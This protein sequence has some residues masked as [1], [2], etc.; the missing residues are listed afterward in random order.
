MNLI[1]IVKYQKALFDEKEF[2][3]ETTST[4][5]CGGS[6]DEEEISPRKSSLTPSTNDNHNNVIEFKELAEIYQLHFLMDDNNFLDNCLLLIYRKY[7]LRKIED[8]DVILSKM[9]A[10]LQNFLIEYRTT[11]GK[12]INSTYI[13]RMYKKYF[14]Y[15]FLN[16]LKGRNITSREC[17]KG[18]LMALVFREYLLDFCREYSQADERMNYQESNY[19]IFDPTRIKTELQRLLDLTS[20]SK[21]ELSQEENVRLLRTVLV[22]Q[23][24]RGYVKG[25]NNKELFIFIAQLLEGTPDLVN[26]LYKAGGVPSIERKIREELFKAL[27][28]A[29]NRVRNNSK[30]RKFEE[31]DD[32]DESLGTKE[33]HGEQ[34]RK[35]AK[36]I[37]LI[38]DK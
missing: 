13:H 5:G 32:T 29:Q 33:N 3:N 31:N 7:F 2:S 15:E 35:I 24:L 28:G 6:S 26:R 12:Y 18:P 11:N 38:E 37:H 20:F 4:E 23:L 1:S 19:I 30:K 21:I 17:L 8:N 34:I 9:R 10:I 16:E 36:R 27:T 22:F 14:N 25:D